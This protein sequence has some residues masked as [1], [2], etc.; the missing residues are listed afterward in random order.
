MGDAPDEGM[1]GEEEARWAACG[2]CIGAA[3]SPRVPR[4]LLSEGKN[5]QVND[6]FYRTSDD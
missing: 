2:V 4:T 6:E 5:R 1:T 3:F